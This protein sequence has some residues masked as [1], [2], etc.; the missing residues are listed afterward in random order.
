MFNMH[1]KPLEKLSTVTQSLFISHLVTD[2]TFDRKVFASILLLNVQSMDKL[3]FV[4]SDIRNCNILC[5][6]ALPFD[7]CRLIR[8]NKEIQQIKV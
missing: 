8:Q 5:E 3:E 6:A 2:L 1:L 7:F 4:F